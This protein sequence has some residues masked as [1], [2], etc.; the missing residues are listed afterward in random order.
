M[1]LKDEIVMVKYERHNGQQCDKKRNSQQ[2]QRLTQAEIIDRAQESVRITLISPRF[3]HHITQHYL[4]HIPQNKG[5][6]CESASDSRPGTPVDRSTSV[7]ICSP[8]ALHTC[9]D[10]IMD[11]HRPTAHTT[12]VTFPQHIAHEPNDLCRNGC[13]TTTWETVSFQPTNHS[14]TSHAFLQSKCTSSIPVIR[15]FNQKN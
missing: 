9:S 14:T 10:S 12:Q 1:P 4:L 6:T 8:C 7:R 11:Q 2:H 3:T 5:I 13:S 15:T